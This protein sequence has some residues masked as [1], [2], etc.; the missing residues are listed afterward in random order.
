MHNASSAADFGCQ[1]AMPFW[2]GAI[3]CDVIVFS[4]I[5]NEIILEK[6][7][8]CNLDIEV[9]FQR[10]MHHQLQICGAQQ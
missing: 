3:Q 9:L 10:T 1:A 7:E 4:I 6:T 2:D 5:I 8:W